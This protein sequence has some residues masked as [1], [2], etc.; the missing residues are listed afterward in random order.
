MSPVYLA[1]TVALALLAY[2]YLLA[3]PT[4]AMIFLGR[5][6]FLAS[7]FEW[8]ALAQS[9]FAAA[10]LALISYLL[11][12]IRPTPPKLLELPES[13]APRLFEMIEHVRLQSRAPRLGRVFIDEGM[14]V[15]MLY[16]PLSGFPFGWSYSLVIGLPAMQLLT[17]LHFKGL[18]AR[19]LGQASRRNNR[20]TGWLSTLRYLGPGL[21]SACPDWRGIENIVVRIFFLWYDPLYRRVSVRAARADELHADNYMMDLVNDRDVA[22]LMCAQIIAE[23]YLKEHYGPAIM[24]LARKR[25]NPAPVIYSGIDRKFNRYWTS[26]DAK[27]W[28]QIAF[29]KVPAANDPM[30]PLRDRLLEIGHSI[31]RLPAPMRQAASRVLL[32]GALKPV[33][34][35]L[36]RAWMRRVA[37]DWRELHRKARQETRR[38]GLLYKKSRAHR[39]TASEAREMAVLVERCHGKEK[40]KPFFRQ[41]LKLHAQDAAAN[42]AAGRFLL[43]VDDEQGVLILEKVARMDERF[44]DRAETLI[45]DYRAE[46]R[47]R[48][49]GSGEYPSISDT[50]LPIVVTET[51]DVVTET[52]IRKAVSEIGEHG[53][54]T[55]QNL[56]SAITGPRAP[57][58]PIA[59]LGGAVSET[60]LRGAAAIETGLRGVESRTGQPVVATERAGRRAGA[61]PRDASDTPT[62]TELPAVPAA[63]EKDSDTLLDRALARTATRNP[64]TSAG[65]QKAID[66]SGGQQ[67]VSEQPRSAKPKRSPEADLKIHSR[68]PKTD[69]EKEGEK[70]YAVLRASVTGERIA[71]TAYTTGEQIVVS[72]EDDRPAKNLEEAMA[73]TAERGSVTAARL[74]TALTDSA[75]RKAITKERPVTPNR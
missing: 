62:V 51:P 58:E 44:S 8:L 6:T 46:L 67:A 55:D 11:Y 7:R 34:A 54:V 72:D 36:D 59:G 75:I 9:A 20:L 12:Q 33:M 22:E 37:G 65:L 27:R 19:R 17:P 73:R 24:D 47:R 30:A 50:Q 41:L 32:E 38:L 25:P 69:A 70:A 21:L 18:V 60:G 42:F 74:Q 3:F 14:D 16:T 52:Q 49:S 61:L 29:A 35:K 63:A 39:L 40:A 28:L 2:V 66:A 53:T 23:R 10:A 48:E 64:V 57:A 1:G 68:K 43:S 5:A 45:A 31:P 4:L 71:T 13:S 26:S 56:R 15:R